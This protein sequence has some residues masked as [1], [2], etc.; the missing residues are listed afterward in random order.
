MSLARESRLTRRAA[1]HWTLVRTYRLRPDLL[2]VTHVWRADGDRQRIVVA[3]KGAPEAIAASVPADAA[4]R[5]ALTRARRRDGAAACACSA[6]RA[7]TRAGPTC[8]TS[9]RELRFEFL[10]LVGL[11]DP[12]RASGRPRRFANAGPPASASS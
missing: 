7:R 6:W 3:A 9:P 8:R 11:A 1:S 2:G 5:A 4:D 12:L 10:G